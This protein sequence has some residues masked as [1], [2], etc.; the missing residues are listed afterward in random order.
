MAKTIKVVL[1]NV[2]VISI[3]AFIFDGRE[4]YTQANVPKTLVFET[5]FS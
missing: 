3:P 1:T 2:L 4:C 5:P